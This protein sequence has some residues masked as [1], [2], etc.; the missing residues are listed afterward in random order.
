MINNPCVAA[1]DGGLPRNQAAKRDAM[2]QGLCGE[3]AER[4]LKVD[5]GTMWNFMHRNS[6]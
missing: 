5:N 1:V 6:A 2:L 3:L 4:G